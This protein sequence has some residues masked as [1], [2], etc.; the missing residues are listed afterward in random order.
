MI[1]SHDHPKQQRRRDQ[2]R[3]VGCI[4]VVLIATSSLTVFF[5]VLLVPS[6]SSSNIKH[7]QYEIPN[8]VNYSQSPF[9]S[10]EAVIL[11]DNNNTATYK[12]ILPGKNNTYNKIMTTDY[13]YSY[14]TT[15]V[16]EFR[17]F[18]R[19][20]LQN[21]SSLST[22]TTTRARE[23]DS[24][25]N[26][27]TT[28]AFASKNAFG[29]GAGFRNQMMAL[30][31]LVLHANDDGHDQ[32]LLD[33]LWHKDTYGTNQFDPFDFYFDVETWNR[34]SSSGIN[35]GGD[36]NEKE[37]EATVVDWSSY[38]RGENKTNPPRH[39][40]RLP[41][42]VLYNSTLHNQWNINV[43]K[44]RESDIAGG[45]RPYGYTKGASRLAAG[46]QFYVKGGGRYA[47]KDEDPNQNNTK[48]SMT[49]KHRNPAEI[50]M[51]QGALKPNPAL[52]AI[53]DRSKIHLQERASR[54]V[55]AFRYMTLHAR[56]EPDMQH[57]PVCKEKKVLT[58]QEIVDMVESKWPEPPVDIVFLPINRQYIEQEGIIPEKYKNES[59]GDGDGDGVGTINWIAVDNLRVLNRLTNDTATGGGMWNGTIP[60][61]EFGSEALQGTVYEQRPSTSGS[62][63]NY[64]L[65]LGADIFVGTEVSSFSHDVL[66]ARFYRGSV[67]ENFKYLPG[68]G[69][70]EWITDDMIAPPG[71]LC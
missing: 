26:L 23:R 53:V 30:T 9:N 70:Q 2:R 35:N 52:Q 58:L 51:L 20:Y 27:A 45:T 40:K 50:L 37:K 21:I 54:R 31:M 13:S 14:G 71:F 49:G 59:N 61:V 44:Y 3:G 65:S 19:N 4:V 55:G 16:A 28:Y 68:G 36:D 34:Y 47:V 42:M 8:V 41:R 12:N 66:A 39:P 22:T 29:F 38:S 18:H 7:E 56:V 63:L 1:A 5:N 15:D 25:G 33:S 10:A 48:T 6:P 32:I 62:I 57:H 17:R 69:L 24:N 60:V 43:S 64:F 67:N 46:Y 11:V